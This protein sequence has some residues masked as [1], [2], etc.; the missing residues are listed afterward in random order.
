MNST[1]NAMNST[2]KMRR[3]SRRTRI[4]VLPHC[5]GS[6]IGAGRSRPYRRRGQTGG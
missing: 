5:A 2:I 1:I 3:M 6:G 4:G